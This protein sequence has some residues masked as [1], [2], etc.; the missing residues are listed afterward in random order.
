[1]PLITDNRPVMRYFHG[2]RLP[3]ELCQK[4][5]LSAISLRTTA[6]AGRPNMAELGA[7][8]AIVRTQ[9]RGPNPA[10][11]CVEVVIFRRHQTVSHRVVEPHGN[12]TI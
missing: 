10:A 4:T 12:A 2:G 1:M 9:S 3:Y 11:N 8:S 5:A 6:T 7:K